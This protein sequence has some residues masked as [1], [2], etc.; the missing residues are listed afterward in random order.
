LA[1]T[2][3]SSTDQQTLVGTGPVSTTSSTI[4]NAKEVMG[5]SRFIQVQVNGGFRVSNTIDGGLAYHSQDAGT[6]GSSFFAWDGNP[7]PGIQPSGLGGVNI[8]ADDATAFKV[9]IEAYDF[10]TAQPMRLVFSVY[11]ASDPSGTKKVSVGSLQLTAAISDPKEFL[12]PYTDFKKEDTALEPADF[13]NVGA[14]TLFIDGSNSV[15]HD[16]ILSFIGT[17]GRCSH[18]PVNGLVVDKCGV[19]NGNNASCS[20]C[21]GTPNGSKI[22]GTSCATGSLGVCGEGSFSGKFPTCLC[23]PSKDPGVEI[24]DGLDND[25]D[26]EIDEGKLSQGPNVDACGICKG[27]GSTCLTCD[28]VNITSL[29]QALDGGA[30]EQERVI[31]KAVSMLRSFPRA[32][33][34]AQFISSTL[35]GAHRAQ[36]ENWTLS[37]SLPQISTTCSNQSSVCTSTSNKTILEKYRSNNVLLKEFSA[38]VLNKVKSYQRGRLSPKAQG[39]QTAASKWY[40]ANLRLSNKVP[41]QQFACTGA[42]KINTKKL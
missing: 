40:T 28:S 13:T 8:L 31:T 14:I 24:C 20:D 3:H 7:A 11:D 41:E 35:Q 42:V 37:W 18:V 5:G 16:L 38:N 26:G 2:E 33:K 21:E 25:C 10:P 17:N 9:S 6:K 27:D 15:A 30:K 32:R 36:L 12:L 39:L 29:I 1:P 19:C 4:T 23:K 34:E 22:D